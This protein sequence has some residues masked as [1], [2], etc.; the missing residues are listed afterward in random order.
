MPFDYC[1]G[2]FEALPVEIWN[3]IIDFVSYLICHSID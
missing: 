1:G 3:L 2:I